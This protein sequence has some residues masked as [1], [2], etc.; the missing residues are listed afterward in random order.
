MVGS[1]VS[2]GQQR[3][4]GE[5]AVFGETHDNRRL[6]ARRLPV[7]GQTIAGHNTRGNPV[8]QVSNVSR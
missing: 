8:S 6:G 3:V 4:F 1:R 7:P 5:R 2:P